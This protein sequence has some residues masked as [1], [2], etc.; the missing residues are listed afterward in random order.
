M[1]FE[2]MSERDRL[3]DA[4]HPYLPK[5]SIVEW[6][7]QRLIKR[8]MPVGRKKKKAGKPVKYSAMA[9]WFEPVPDGPTQ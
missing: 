1:I 9:F 6:N 4:E 2:P 8:Y 3:I 7:G 5:G